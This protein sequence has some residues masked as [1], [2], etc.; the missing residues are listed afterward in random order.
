[1]PEDGGQPLLDLGKCPTNKLR[2]E[3]LLDYVYLTVA[4]HLYRCVV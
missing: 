3:A 4:T 1:M 2:Q